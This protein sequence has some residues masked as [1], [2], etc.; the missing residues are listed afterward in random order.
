L[1]LHSGVGAQALYPFVLMGA[2]VG[3]V[4]VIRK[5]G[6]V[7]RSLKSNEER[8]Q[9]TLRELLTGDRF[10]PQLYKDHPIARG[11]ANDNV[12]TDNENFWGGS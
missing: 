2:A 4:V 9:N 7:S 6:P 8:Q 12:N 5:Y 10:C 1:T 11:M 3:A